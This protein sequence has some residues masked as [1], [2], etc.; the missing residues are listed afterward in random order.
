MM[1]RVRSRLPVSI[2]A[3][4][5]MGLILYFLIQ[6]IIGVKPI[7]VDGAK[8]YQRIE[9]FGGSGAYYEW[10]L[11]NLREPYRTEVA[12]LLFSDLGINI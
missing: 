5:V 3:M 11:R 10:L 9:G 1:L 8:R 6:S 2:L 4:V 7:E 12:D